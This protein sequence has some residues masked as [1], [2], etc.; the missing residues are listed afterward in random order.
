MPPGPL[1]RAAMRSSRVERWLEGKETPLLLQ[2][3]TMGETLGVGSFGEVR[4]GTLPSGEHCAVKLMDPRKLSGTSLSEMVNEVNALAK[5]RHVHVI[6]Y[7]GMVADGSCTSR[8]C[9]DEYCGCLDFEADDDG[10]CSKCGHSEKCHATHPE[11]RSAVAIVQELAAGGDLVSLLF[12]SSLGYRM[13][14]IIPRTYFHQLL[15]GIEYCHSQRICHG[16]IKPENLCLNSSAMLKIVDFG[17]CHELGSST[18]GGGGSG[19]GSGG[20]SG[21]SSCGSGGGG[22]H[23]HS[24]CY[25]APEIHAKN[26]EFDRQAADVWSCGV[27]LYMMIAREVPF[28]YSDGIGPAAMR[29]G[30][31][32][33]PA[34]MDGELRS[35]IRYMLDPNPASRWTIEQVKQ[36][37][38]YRR[39]IM[40]QSD[41]SLRMADHMQ[42]SWVEQKKHELVKLLQSPQHSHK[43]SGAATA[44]QGGELANPPAASAAISGFDGQPFSLSSAGESPAPAPGM[45]APSQTI[46]HLSFGVAAVPAAGG[47]VGRGGGGGATEARAAG[48]GGGGGGGGA[49]AAARAGAGGIG[50]HPGGMGSDGDRVSYHANQNPRSRQEEQPSTTT[51]A[52]ELRLA[53]QPVPDFSADDAA[54]DGGGDRDEAEPEAEADADTQAQVQAIPAMGTATMQA[55]IH[56]GI[57]AVVGATDFDMTGSQR[58]AQSHGHSHP[59]SAPT[60]PVSVPS[61]AT[62]GVSRPGTPELSITVRVHQLWVWLLPRCWTVMHP[63]QCCYRGRTRTPGSAIGGEAT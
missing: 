40:P 25:T 29:D 56:T 36:H 45:S 21:W 51:G 17:L 54:G 42:N 4:V 58:H 20:G 1:R 3:L 37:A 48:G 13:D 9:N 38:W 19:R 52:T 50:D 41:L 33:W 8:W 55:S 5:L 15:D 31:F 63:L 28:E 59:F 47:G 26:V 22:S 27:V 62:T 34:T 2:G 35:L 12:T 32:P 14:D 49:A 24:G 23:V 6:R 44:A 61:V 10:C 16:D 46:R 18:R 30:T 39:P 60:L 43:S 7:Y 57:A 11:K 53:S